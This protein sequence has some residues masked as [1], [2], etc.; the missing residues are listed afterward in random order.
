MFKCVAEN[1][2]GEAEKL[3]RVDVMTAP[4]RHEAL[5]PSEYRLI[6]GQ[7]IEIGCPVGGMPKPSIVWLLNTHRVLEK[8]GE[9]SARGVRLVKDKVVYERYFI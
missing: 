5:W 7:H 8:G 9:E 2:A 4:H 6:E 3:F 1:L